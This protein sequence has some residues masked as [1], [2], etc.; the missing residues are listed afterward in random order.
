MT[1]QSISYRLKQASEL[2]QEKGPIYLLQKSTNYLSSYYWVLRGRKRVT[3]NGYEIVFQTS[4]PA[5][6]QQVRRAMS[7]ERETIQT[8]LE[9]L[10]P[11]DIFYDIGSNIGVYACFGVKAT[12]NTVVAFEPE[13][14]NAASLRANIELN[15]DDNSLSR[16]LEI[17]LSNSE[18][19]V[20]FTRPEGGKQISGT[21]SISESKANTTTVRTNTLDNLVQNESLPSPT[22]LKIDVEGAEQMVLEGMKTQLED[23][24]LRF[25][26]VELHLQADT[27]PSIYD[28]GGEPEQVYSLLRDA[29]FTLEK[30][31]RGTEIHCFARR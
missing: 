6:A 1:L 20:E 17:A 19:S 2:L 14:H 18:G 16:V 25:I 27:R 26:F 29:G 15:S 11:S 10:H 12:K 30:Q 9:E 28:F 23:N 3:L 5:E 31:V 4:S 24:K 22:V 7:S 13:P 21:T 8:I